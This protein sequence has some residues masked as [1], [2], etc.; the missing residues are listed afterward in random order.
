MWWKEREKECQM[1]INEE[2]DR[3]I[4]SGVKGSFIKAINVLVNK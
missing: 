2:K 3:R 1:N 4:F